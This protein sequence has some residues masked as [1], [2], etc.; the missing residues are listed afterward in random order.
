MS[1]GGTRGL[2]PPGG[3]PPPT[4]ATLP[5]GTELDLVALAKEVCARYRAE[6]PDEAERYGDAG[7]SWCVHDNQHILRWAAV[8]LDDEPGFHKE[9]GWL[10]GV[11][12]ARDFPLYRLARDL[13]IAAEVVAEQ[14]LGEPGADLA[15]RLRSGVPV[16]D[17]AGA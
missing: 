17:R 10:A 15:A 7:I 2:R 14:G 8:T 11:L 5:G 12:A 4:A 3:Y 9:I 6:F 1:E 13:G 16:V